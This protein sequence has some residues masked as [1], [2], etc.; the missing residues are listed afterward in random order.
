[1]E[2]IE[3]FA[4]KCPCWATNLFQQGL[5]PGDKRAD[6]RYQTFYRL[7]K[8]KKI[9]LMLH[10]LGCARA[11]ADYQAERWNSASND[12]G[13]CH[14]AIDSN[15][16]NFRQT[17]R[18]DM[19][20]WHCGRSGN[21]THIGI[22]MCES[23]EIVYRTDKPWLFTFKNKER[24]QQHCRTAYKGAVELFAY[25]CKMFGCDPLTDICS[26]KEGHAMGIA[27]NH[28][29]PEHYW[30]GMGLGYTMDGFRADVKSKIEEMTELTE[31]Q[32]RTIVNEAVSAAVAPINAAQTTINKKLSELGTALDGLVES[33]PETVRKGVK[34]YLKE[35][36]A[37]ANDNDAAKWSESARE[38][39]IA[40]GLTAGKGP[41][42]DG[43][44]NYAW[45][46]VLTFERFMTCLYRYDQ[47]K[48]A[49]AAAQN[50]T[51]ET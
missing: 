43:Q 26:H 33:L 3:R 24:A 7:F 48:A 37:A 11:S 34:A 51:P 47:I 38:W 36:E 41:G 49:L 28:G 14:G 50:E 15:D 5:D 1:M 4:T 45:E 40:S 13:I 22:E 2:I 8:Q 19:R 44:P 25:L 27:S 18:W 23:D 30:A 39:A 21:D 46:S 9:K 10:S 17:L 32:I 12:A 35:Q 16:G 6:S 20:G 29:D 42:P 31:N